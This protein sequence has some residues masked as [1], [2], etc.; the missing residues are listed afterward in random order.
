[1]MYNF[2]FFPHFYPKFNRSYP[3]NSSKYVNNTLSYPTSYAINSSNSLYRNN[4]YH[5]NNTT[6][7]NTS[8][9]IRSSVSYNEKSN[10][11]SSHH[12]IKEKNSSDQTEK[13][14]EEDR[15][16]DGTDAIFEIFGMQLHFDDILLIC[17]IFFLYNEGVK[18][19][20]LFIA[21]ILLLLS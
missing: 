6:L 11:T 13:N 20:F 14:K 4:N 21:L 5:N 18:D 12:T 1:M 8:H 2:P 9:R 3:Q 7:K 19:E 10:Q 17:L 16:L 15:L